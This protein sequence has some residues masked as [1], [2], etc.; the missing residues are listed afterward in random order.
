MANKLQGGVIPDTTGLSL[1]AFIRSTSTNAGLA[2]LA[3]TDIVVSYFRQGASAVV[4]PTITA[5]ASLT[6]A[7][8]GASAAGWRE[9]GGGRY[10]LDIPDNAIAAEVDPADNPDWV[11]LAVVDASGTDFHP[12]ELTL[13]LEGSSAYE[14]SQGVEVTNTP[15]VNVTQINSSTL[16]AQLQAYGARVLVSG[17]VTATITPTT[18]TCT[19]DLPSTADD[20]WVDA[21]NPRKLYWLDGAANAN[22][23]QPITDY[24]NS[25]RQLTYSAF[26]NAPVVGDRFVISA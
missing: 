12:W 11:H 1:V 22:L 21:T 14:L 5:L 24:G 7:H 6:A 18:T 17:T 13:A 23:S 10:R 2:S 15:N 19:T 3:S 25:N 26:P 4:T 9:I 8:S 16:A 20:Y